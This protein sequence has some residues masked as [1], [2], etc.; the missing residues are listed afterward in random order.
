MQTQAKKDEADMLRAQALHEAQEQE[1]ER[2]KARKRADRERECKETI[3]RQ[4]CVCCK[5][6]SAMSFT[7][8]VM[9]THTGG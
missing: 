5:R 9:A 4:V 8:S 6:R 2:L 7:G 3:A 1:K